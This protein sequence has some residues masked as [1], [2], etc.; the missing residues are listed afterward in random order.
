MVSCLLENGA[1]PTIEN[2]R[3]LLPSA[4]ST[5]EAIVALLEKFAVKVT[6]DILRVS[7]SYYLAQV[8][9]WHISAL[10]FASGLWL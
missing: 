7:S 9:M 3:G 4:Y 10:S 2:N 8:G 5:N 6:A 1:D